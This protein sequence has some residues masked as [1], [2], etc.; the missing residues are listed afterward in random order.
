MGEEGHLPPAV[1]QWHA[2]STLGGKPCTRPPSR[3]PGH[4]SRR[5]GRCEGRPAKQET[6]VSV[7]RGCASTN[8]SGYTCQNICSRSFDLIQTWSIPQTIIQI[9]TRNNRNNHP[10][11]AHHPGS[12]V[13]LEVLRGEGGV[14]LDRIRQHPRIRGV[15]VAQV[16][17]PGGNVSRIVFRVLV[18][19]SAR[20][21][22]PIG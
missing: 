9:Q 20:V 12:S 10:Y 14:R 1:S 13:H 17:V 5:R 22:I 11:P 7:L 21:E 3:W 15:D 16:Y 19:G 18:M 8:R 4:C 6:P 2:V